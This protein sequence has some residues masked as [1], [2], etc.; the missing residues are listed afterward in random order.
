MNER[1]IG[2]KVQMDKLY[3][4]KSAIFGHAVGDKKYGSSENPIGRLGLH[5]SK[6][7]FTHPKN[8]KEITITAKSERKFTLPK[9]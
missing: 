8:G 9:R 7:S 5:A 1:V 2:K 6:I 3:M 4:I